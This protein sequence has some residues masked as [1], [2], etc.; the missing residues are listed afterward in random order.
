MKNQA[1]QEKFFVQRGLVELHYPD[2]FEQGF[3][4]LEEAENFYR[5]MVER[6]PTASW[7]VAQWNVEK[8]TFDVFKEYPT[9]KKN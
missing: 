6:H 9:K 2:S 4:T 1:V 8:R 7:R 3:D 5:E